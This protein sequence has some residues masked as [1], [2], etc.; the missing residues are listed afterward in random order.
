MTDKKK[1]ISCLR[2]AGEASIQL[3][4]KLLSSDSVLVAFEQVVDC[5][6]EAFDAHRTVYF[7][8]AIGGSGSKEFMVT[9]QTGEDAIVV[10]NLCGYAGNTEAATIY[11]PPSPPL[12][13]PIPPAQSIATPGV[14]TIQALAKTLKV[15]ESETVKTLL[16]TIDA[17]NILI[18]MRG[19]RELNDIKL[20][21]AFNAT[22]CH[23][24]SSDTV[25]SITGA[26]PGSVGPINLKNPCPIYVD[27]ELKHKTSFIVGAN[28]DDH[29]LIYVVPNRDFQVTGWGDFGSAKVDD[30]CGHCQSGH[31]HE[32][33]G[34]EVGHIFKLGETYSK[35]MQAQILNE[36]GKNIH[37]QMGCY[38]IGVSRIMAAAI[39]QN[40]D[41]KGILWPIALAPF[42][43]IIIL[44][45]SKDETLATAATTLY[46]DLQ[47]KG[48]SCLL[49]DRPLSIGGKFKD[50]DLI[51]I[52][53]Q[54]VVGKLYKEEETFECVDR[55]SGVRKNL[56]QSALYAYL[57][58]R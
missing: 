31:Y 43:V 21:S 18:L 51:G 13:E 35:K 39:E 36:A 32:V 48:I 44:T 57:N 26:H 14:K 19:D 5:V 54:I 10:C 46:E 25:L 41:E 42:R 2:A 27:T 12:T 40:H 56:D 33:R 1:S 37:M 20:K 4:A 47:A 38:G 16:Y 24:A 11:T 3:K 52:P 17:Q 22:H 7:C 34:I 9:A 30:Y 6:V 28:Q 8:G 55:K 15:P 58:E 49:D 53:T 45:S 29:H 23:M 50:A